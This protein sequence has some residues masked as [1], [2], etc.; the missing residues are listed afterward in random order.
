[1][2]TSSKRRSL[3]ETEKNAAY[4][5]LY[6][7]YEVKRWIELMIDEELP[8]ITT[9]EDSLCNGVFLCKLAMK[10]LPDDPQWR[11][12]YDLD[13]AKFKSKGLDFRHTDNLN[14][15]INSL[16]KLGLPKV[17]YPSVSDIFDSK[18]HM[19]LVYCLHALK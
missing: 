13:Q 15:F 19:K 2:E 8:I 18:N 3:H 14:F 11:K 9:F 12:V 6:R 16:V 5:Y 7:L 1:M 17:F 4:E 10:L